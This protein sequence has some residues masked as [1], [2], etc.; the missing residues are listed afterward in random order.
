VLIVQINPVYRKGAPKTAREIMDRVNEITFN[1]SLL[2]E[3]RAIE[4]V[5]RLLEEGRLD[6]QDYNAVRV[7]MIGEPKLETL[8]ASSKMNTEWV[9]LQYLRDLGRS[10]AEKWTSEDWQYVGKKSSIAL[11]SLFQGRENE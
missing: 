5:A 2:R 7:H 9:F 4:F 11:R 3:F 1:A 10:A 8:G 6:P